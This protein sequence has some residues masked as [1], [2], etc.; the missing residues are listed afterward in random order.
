MVVNQRLLLSLRLGLLAALPLAGL[1]LVGPVRADALDD[2]KARMKVE[3]QRVERRFADER[4]AAYKL[5]R[6]ATPNYFDAA[7]KIYALQSMLE[8][9]T[10]LAPARRTQL[11][12]TLKFDLDNL[13]KVAGEHR[14]AA[15]VRDSDL[16]REAARDALRTAPRS[17]S[18]EMDRKER[19]R[20]IDSIIGSRSKAVADARDSKRR[21]GERWVA[22]GREIDKSALPPRGDYTLPKNWLELSKKRTT[23]KMT[24][25]ERAIMKA[26]NT[27]ISVEYDNNLSEVIDSLEKSTGQ[28]IIL[29]KQGMDEAGVT[30]ETMVKLKLKATTRTVLKRV[31]SDLNLA[32]VVKEEKIFITSAARARQMTTTRVYYI[33]DLMPITDVRMPPILNQ[34]RM[35]ETVNQL[36]LTITKTIEPQSWQVNNPDAPGTITFEPLTMTLIVK[37]TAEMHF[38]MGGFR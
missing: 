1:F 33:G 16:A 17:R 19:V 3:A 13:K 2:A 18:G 24:A 14:K 32:Y 4:L 38:Q 30:Y 6:T 37:Q 27:V 29:D 28:T 15:A 34:L 23:F 10:S 8:A 25:T 21:S 7:D 5:V 26:L 20:E 31:L 22:V 35:V 11:L 36:I 12:N 9:D